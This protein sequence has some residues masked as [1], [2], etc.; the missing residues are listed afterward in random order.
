MW[1]V[2]LS[3]ALCHLLAKGRVC[4]TKVKI[5]WGDC[6]STGFFKKRSGK[7][8]GNDST[9]KDE[10]RFAPCHRGERVSEFAATFKSE[11]AFVTYLMP[12]K[13]GGKFRFCSVENRLP[14]HR[15]SDKQSLSFARP[16]DSDTLA[17]IRAEG[18]CPS[19]FNCLLSRQDLIGERLHLVV[20]VNAP[21]H[22]VTGCCLCAG[23]SEGCHSGTGIKIDC[24]GI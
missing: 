11:L 14:D 22:L 9:G 19:R 5:A 7:F 21:C 10:L 12:R 20:Y 1:F 8:S 23:L 13:I 24:G 6:L 15:K 16:N 2:V 17:D 4:R 18:V 3:A